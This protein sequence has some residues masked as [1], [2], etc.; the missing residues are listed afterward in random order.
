VAATAA[1]GKPQCSATLW[2]VAGASVEV[3][4]LVARVVRIADLIRGAIDRRNVPSGQAKGRGWPW[5]VSLRVLNTTARFIS[6]A[7]LRTQRLAVVSHSSRSLPQ[8]V[9]QPGLR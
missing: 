7:M 3:Q 9:S 6:G 8:A 5:N 2:S 1:I 4:A